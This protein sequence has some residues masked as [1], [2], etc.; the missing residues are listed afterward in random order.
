MLLL[1]PLIP[2]TGM[3]FPFSNPFVGIFAGKKQQD[4]SPQAMQTLSE[5]LGAS[6]SKTRTQ[7]TVQRSLELGLVIL[8]KE[9]LLSVQTVNLPKKTSVMLLLALYEHQLIIKLALIFFCY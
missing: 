2:G 7:T 5:G 4:G 3:L 9:D 6:F 1:N 8:Q